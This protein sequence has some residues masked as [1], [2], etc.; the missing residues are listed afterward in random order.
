MNQKRLHKIFSAASDCSKWASRVAWIAVLWIVSTALPAQSAAPAR[1]KHARVEQLL[2]KMTLDEKIQLLHG[3][4]EDALTGQGQAGFLQGIPRLGIP[5]LRLADGPPGVLTRIPAAAPTA[6][7]GLAA[8]FS[9]T[10]ARLNGELVAHEARAR[11]IDVVLQPFINIDRDFRWPRAYNTYG[12][13]PLLT[14]VM[15]AEFI[16]GVQSQGVMAQAKH[17]IGYDTNGADVRID[18]QTLHEIYLEPFADAVDA[19]VS[20]IMCSYNRINAHYSCDNTETLK[21]I[22]KGE[23]GFK[24]FVTSDW[25]ATHS[26]NFINAGLDMEMPGPL[27][28]PW[29]TSSFF[30]LNPPRAAELDCG[31]SG[32][33]LTDAGL[34]EEPRP[35]TESGSSTPEP[36]PSVDLKQLVARGIVSEKTIDDAVRRVLFEM[37]RFGL[38]DRKTE[39]RIDTASMAV[40][41]LKTLRKTADDAAV[42]L[43]NQDAMLPLKADSLADIALVGPDAGRLVAVGQIGE[44]AV[45]L[46]ELEVSPLEA[47]RKLAGP[48]AHIA[49]AAADDWDGVPVPARFLSHFGKPGLERREFKESAVHIDAQVDFTRT[50]NTS[51]PARESVVWSGTLT[52]PASG[53]YRLHLQLLGCIG[54]LE[55]DGHLVARNSFNWIHGEIVQA[56]QDGVAPTADGLDNLRAAMPLTAGPHR[57]RVEVDPDGSNQPTQVRLSWVTPQQQIGDYRAAVETARH[58]K[59]A[60]VFA[61]SR[62]RPVFGL[63]GDQDKLIAD[64]AAANPNT[65][66]VLNVSQPVAMP[67]LDKV[68]AVLNM[69][70]PGD[71]GGWATADLLLGRV[72]PAGRLPFTWPRRLQ[73]MPTDDPAHPERSNEGIHGVTTYSEGIFVGYRW[74]DSRKIDPLFPFGFGLS[75][76][77]FAYSDL[78]VEP[79]AD[80]GADVLF[81]VKNT[82]SRSG[83]E[84]AQVYLSAPENPPTTA[85]FAVRALAGFERVSLPLGESRLLSIHL[86]SRSFQYWSTADSEWKIASGE[87]TVFVGA[88]SRDL[89]LHAAVVPSPVSADVNGAIHVS[90]LSRENARP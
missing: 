76:T 25:G 17:Y 35:Q 31:K 34:P 82:G 10:D 61:W 32:P 8:T 43:K 28:E 38:L 83:D 53:T 45:G 21:K 29:T 56:G 40:N 58:A 73:D 12:E 59:V 3:T 9:T 60:V 84:V 24:G 42:L 71:K 46:P 69:W 16:R 13:D 57:I 75:Y 47:L 54:R 70:W 89:R 36:K 81:K 86:G 65:I 27:P 79:S 62:L 15:G 64:V 77:Q 19:G 33:A 20:S 66:V 90:H 72:N 26:T 85:Q 39:P 49:Y 44:K 80:G 52:A 23:L 87:R 63:P 11:G 37:D 78:R 7:M 67:W 48:G 1:S 18:Q 68:K 51:L 14:G 30:E 55:I 74:F 88:S 6:T 50:A 22:L 5:S 4:G 2:H 41:D